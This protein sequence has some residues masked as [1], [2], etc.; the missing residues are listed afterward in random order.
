MT[1]GAIVVAVVAAALAPLTQIGSIRTAFDPHQ[2]DNFRPDTSLDGDDV[3][4][5]CDKWQTLRRENPFEVFTVT[6]RTSRKR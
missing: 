6:G 2:R 4:T 5:L 1:V 3:V